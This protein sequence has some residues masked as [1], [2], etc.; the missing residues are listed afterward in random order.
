MTASPLVQTSGLLAPLLSV[1]RDHPHRFTAVMAKCRLGLTDQLLAELVRDEVVINSPELVSLI[2]AILLSSPAEGVQA[3]GPIIQLCA[4][5]LL[6][7]PVSDKFE[8]LADVQ[9]HVSMAKL[10]GKMLL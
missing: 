8:D 6:H 7:L 10:S 1:G 9:N 4:H 2:L 5:I 3:A